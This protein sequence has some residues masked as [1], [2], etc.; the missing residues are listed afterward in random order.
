MLAVTLKRFGIETTLV[1][2]DLP[3]EELEQS[4]SQIPRQYLQRP[5][6]ILQV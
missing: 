2:Q 4:F 6:L 3:A 1:D 5:F